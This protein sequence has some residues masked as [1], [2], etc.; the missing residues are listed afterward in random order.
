MKKLSECKKEFDDC[1]QSLM[2]HEEIK[3]FWVKAIAELLEKAVG[4]NK[5]ENDYVFGD[6]PDMD[7]EDRHFYSGQEKGYNQAKNEIREKI[8]QILRS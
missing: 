4:E 6:Y 3:S 5:K 7:N 8:K 2:S 1:S